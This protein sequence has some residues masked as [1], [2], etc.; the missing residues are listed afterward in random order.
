MLY[1]DFSTLITGGRVRVTEDRLLFAVDLTMLVTEKSR[2]ESGCLLRRLDQE[3][4]SQTKFTIR[5]TP[6]KGNAHTRLLT[7]DAAIELV[8]V[9]PGK[10]AKEKRLD[11]AVLLRRYFAGDLTLI[12]EIHA[13]AVSEEPIHVLAREAMP[14]LRPTK[15]RAVCDT[16]DASPQNTDE[17]NVECAPKHKTSV[18]NRSKDNVHRAPDG[19]ETAIVPYRGDFDALSARWEDE[20]KEAIASAVD[21]RVFG[22]CYVA[23]NPCFPNLYKLGVSTRQP[24]HRVQELS[25][26]SVPEPFQLITMLPCWEPF[27][28]EKRIHAHFAVARKYGRRNE[29]FETARAELMAFFGALSVEMTAAAP[30]PSRSAKRPTA[31]VGRGVS[32]EVRALRAQMATQ[33]A[34]LQR[35]I[36]TRSNNNKPFS[37]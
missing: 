32:S 8:M 21:G 2:D 31:R 37:A 19:A 15:K 9:L 27:Q 4:F 17:S 16:P 7:Y 22:Y 26:T 29:F 18:P 20:D 35:L 25:Q 24:I 30:S 23:W 13:N 6:G 12:D 5:Q 14:P 28:V 3:V 34:L 33:T 10:M 11:F 36:L 1:A